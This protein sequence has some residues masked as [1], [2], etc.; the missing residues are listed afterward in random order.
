[1]REPMTDATSALT[2][3]YPAGTVLFEE[4]DPGSRMYVIRRGKVKIARH[5]G[6]HEIVLAMLGPGEFFGEMALL[7]NLPRSATATVTEDAE[8][9]EVD[10]R[11]FEEMVRG[12]VEIAVRVMRKLA[13]RVR[14]LDRRL[15]HLLL[16]SGVGRAVEVLRWLLPNGVP[17]GAYVRLAANTTLVDIAA[18]AGISSTEARDV[19]ARLE[20]A[21]IMRIDG[22]D[23]LIAELK[24]LD[25]YS[26]YLDL[27]RKYDPEPGRGGEREAAKEPATQQQAMR[28]LLKALHISVRDLKH[29]EA[30][31]AAQYN[32][33]QQ[34]KRRFHDQ[35]D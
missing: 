3:S 2:R 11:T 9:V 7:E 20:R 17:A 31:L 23:V 33:Y 24:T 26:T 27:K 1:M 13:S 14:E 32:Q 8:L 30:A 34:L 35:D 10:G 22:A 28:R 21:G 25:D 15:Q 5:N 18:H 4:Y 29:N 12:N 16:E 6:E 19:V